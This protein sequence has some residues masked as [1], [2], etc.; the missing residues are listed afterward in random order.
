VIAGVIA[1]LLLLFF[2]IRFLPINSFGACTKSHAVCRRCV[3]PT[4]LQIILFIKNKKYFGVRHYGATLAICYVCV[5]LI[6]LSEEIETFLRL[7]WAKPGR[8]R[9]CFWLL[10]LLRVLL[11][12]IISYRCYTIP[13]MFS[14]CKG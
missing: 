5:T 6:L 2:N 4:P 3:F 8:R 12:F 7:S 11:F 13:Y 10:I 9:I 14:V 1:F